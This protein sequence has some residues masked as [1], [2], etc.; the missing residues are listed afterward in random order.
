VKRVI[1][2]FLALLTFVTS[3]VLFPMVLPTSANAADDGTPVRTEDFSAYCQA[4]GYPG[5]AKLFA[6]N[7]YGW[8]CVKN[9]S[10]DKGVAISVTA[11][12][13]EVTMKDNSD[14]ILDFLNDYTSVGFYAWECFRLSKI[15]PLGQLDVKKYCKDPTDHGAGGYT[16]AVLLDGKTALSWECQSPNQSLRLDLVDRLTIACARQYSDYSD[17]GTIRA[18]VV[19]FSDPNGI[20]CMV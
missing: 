12:C 16:A 11:V 14:K 7:A 6:Q 5:G 17:L 15:D 13:R 18:R 8:R 1:R 19:D 9:T 3:V 2:P 4:H 20:E 10:D